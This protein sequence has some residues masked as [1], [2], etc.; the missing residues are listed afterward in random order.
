MLQ[1]FLS[2]LLYKKDT[3]FQLYLRFHLNDMENK[4]EDDELDF[5]YQPFSVIWICF[6][7]FIRKEKS[8]PL[9][10]RLNEKWNY[11]KNIF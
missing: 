6:F 3:L 4:G 8:H 2:F 7:F 5:R 1:K 10:F 9:T 11:E